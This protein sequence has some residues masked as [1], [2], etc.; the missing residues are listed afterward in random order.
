[1]EW[2]FIIIGS[3]LGIGGFVVVALWDIAKTDKKLKMWE[4]SNKQK[5]EDYLKETNK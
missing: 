3:I 4:E 5:L 2:T 1:M